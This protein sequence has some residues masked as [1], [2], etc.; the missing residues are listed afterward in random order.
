M[1]DIPWAKSK[2]GLA[3][4]KEKDRFGKP[5][6]CLPA[7]KTLSGEKYSPPDP[8]NWKTQGKENQGNV[9]SFTSINVI[10]GSGKKPHEYGIIYGDLFSSNTLHSSLRL[11]VLLDTGCHGRDTNF[12]SQGV[13]EE[14]VRREYEIREISKVVGSCFVDIK[15]KINQQTTLSIRLTSPIDNSTHIIQLQC[16]V[17]NIPYDVIIGYKTIQKHT[18][19]K[20]IL[21]YG[22]SGRNGGHLRDRDMGTGRE[23]CLIEGD[24][25]PEF[26][27]LRK[28][29]T[30]MT[31]DQELDTTLDN[32]EETKGE[33][34]VTFLGASSDYE[35]IPFD[36]CSEELV[37]S[38][39]GICRKYQSIF[40]LELN[41]N[42]AAVT[43]MT[44]ELETDAKWEIG[45]NR[46]P[47]RTQSFK[48]A[49]EIELQVQQM[50]TAGIIRRSTASAH[51]QVMLTEKTGGKWRFCVDF[52][53]LN[54][55]TRPNH[56]PLPNIKEMLYRI[57][58]KKPKFFAVIDLTKGYYQAPLAEGSKRLTTFITA[59][60]L[61]EWN[62]VAMGL[63]GAPSYFQRVMTT[64]VLNDLVYRILEVYLDDV[65]ITGRTKDEFL[66]NLIAVFKRLK[67]VGITINPRKCKFGL[68]SI[69]YVGHTIN[70]HG[71]HFSKRETSEGDINY[72]T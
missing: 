48:K 14:L 56:W 24:N 60:G 63:T 47:P 5:Y 31:V 40:S 27:Q 1:E 28:S 29:G 61:Y 18:I 43:P 44:V 62:R 52:R 21:W 50:L 23:G 22:L 66:Q 51:S 38:V 67:E 17:I 11:S 4:A 41:K 8:K 42:A 25:N 19:L 12:I 35:E 32:L 64:E 68:R 46:H 72:T 69:E 53:R 49:E 9:L 55:L 70:E 71:T 59:G 58:S 34:L 13:A 30:T 45:D 26:M 6:T 33:T 54:A 2:K 10:D 3:W 20:D 16:D 57:G 15:R 7:N 39:K 37:E 36:I 65:I